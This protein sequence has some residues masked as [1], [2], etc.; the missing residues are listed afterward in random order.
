MHAEGELD[1]S[2]FAD[3]LR[4]SLPPD[5]G[6]R[7]LGSR[8]LAFL[9][10]AAMTEPFVTRSEDPP[11]LTGSRPFVADLGIAVDLHL[12]FV[13]S[14]VAYGRLQA[15]DTAA[16]LAAPGVVA[17][18]T[19]QTLPLKPFV[20]FGDLP[21]E[22]NQPPLADD[23]V[24]YAGQAIAVV[25]AA[26]AAAAIDAADL[27]ALELE[28][29]APLTTT[30]AALRAEPLYPATDDNVVYVLDDDGPDPIGSDT[31][32]IVEMSIANNRVA[33]APLEPD[34]IVVVPTDR[35]VDVWCTSQ[36][37]H[38]V[39]DQLAAM[40]DLD[41]AAIR[42]RSPAVGGGFGGRATILPEFVVAVHIALGQ[43][44]TVRWVGS[45]YENLTGMPHGRGF[46]SKLRMG[47]DND[48]HIVGF[49]C[50]VVAEAG[51]TAHMAGLLMVS[52]RRQATGLYH[53]P[54][55]RWR[56]TAVLTNSTP[57]GAYRGAGQPE[58]N[59]ARER[60]LDVAAKRLDLDPIELRR[61]NLARANDF[62]F[63][64]PGGVTYDGADP[65]A[66][67]D[68]ALS[69]AEADHWRTEQQRRRSSDG[70]TDPSEI[71]IGVANYAQTSGRGQ[72]LDSALV[73]INADGSVLV[74]CAS[75]SHGQGH[76]T[77]WAALVSDRLGV[78]RALIEVID[79]D[80]DIVPTGQS[81]G[82]SRSSQVAASAVVNSCGD[83][84]DQARPEAARRLEASP[85]DLVVVEAGYGLGAGLAVTG[86]PTKRIEWSAL[87]QAAPNDCL[88]A[89][90]NES[91][92]GAAHP[93][94]THVS[95][96]EVD[97]E[98]G[99][100]IVLTHVSVDDCGTVLQPNLLEGQQHGGAVA[101]I[102]QALFESVDYDPMGNP[103][104]SS[105]ATYGLPAAS[106]L[107][108]IL[109]ETVGQP[110]ERNQLG[111]R[112]IGENGC[113]G[114][115]AAVHNAVMDALSD[116][117]VEHIDLPLTPLRIWSA[118]L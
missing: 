26:S 88:A 5:R 92:D 23:T 14:D 49:D 11:L 60:L 82:G 8:P 77:T 102:S 110:T 114:A 3:Q 117:G 34:G 53:V 21:V 73:Q 61:R 1:H 118:L 96:V 115:T 105:F 71:G 66:A 29:L 57:V 42:V 87:A 64:A 35:G 76:Q 27:V 54:K 12:A 63:D 112:G 40:T 91:V 90:R 39:R 25:A 97:T 86:V 79:A 109:T 38:A 89:V 33:S 85:D 18:E 75:P 50:D 37:A 99:E 46:A 6:V 9:C 13:R 84:I 4:A 68:R 104:T 17:V 2:P 30:E 81:T 55:L 94:G 62:P 32:T 44:A 103:V 83:V 41:P 67:M 72:P 43:R 98:T 24:R 22:M 93:S 100:V 36:G 113:N 101:G 74:G 31:T 10:W 16:A 95:I 52:A 106:E 45:R 107:C 51:A 80:S 70:M 47:F 108:S 58:A 48:G 7:S 20:L 111:T 28:A 65:I 19:N 15:V 69:L 116:H 78:D 59:H 56:G